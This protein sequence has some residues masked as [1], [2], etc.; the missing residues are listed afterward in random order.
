[1]T[2][3]LDQALAIDIGTSKITLVQ[4]EISSMEVIQTVT[5]ANSSQISLTDAT[6]HEQDPKVIW[7]IVQRLLLQITLRSSI[8]FISITGQ[9]HGILLLDGE[10]NPHTNLITWRDGRNKV[11][12]VGKDYKGENGCLVQRGYGGSTLAALHSSL[13]SLDSLQVCTIASFIMGKLCGC[14][15]I[16]ETMAASLGLYDIRRKRWNREQIEQ[17]GI[18]LSLFPPVIPSSVRVGTLLM[19]VASQLALSDSVVVCSP[20]GDNQASFIGSSGFCQAGVIN[21]GT[22]GQISVPTQEVTDTPSIEIR[23]LPKKGYLQVYSSLC[24]GWAYVY[25]KE[26][27]KDVLTRFGVTVSDKVL[28]EK[29]D[30]LALASDAESGLFVDTQFLGG[31]EKAD[32][33]GSIRQINTHNLTL[34]NLSRG[35]LEGIVRELHPAGIRTDSMKFLV[36]SG[37]AVRKSPVMASLIEAEF[38]CPVMFAPFLEEAA[39]GSILSC[40]ALFAGSGAQEA[41]RTFYEEHFTTHIGG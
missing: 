7:T 28:Y 30:Q 20:I 13:P 31:R 35:F 41:I 9:M 1:M 15:S 38:G 26:F 34:S 6:M 17:L 22:G 10:G 29:L 36:A 32:T 24:G 5:E 3:P 16:D 39:I 12:P 23:P 2:N 8:Q 33:L 18:P 37:N 11:N 25:L 14:F 40:A 27:C 4:F 19:P 21:I